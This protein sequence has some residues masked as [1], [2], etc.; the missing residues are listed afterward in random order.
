MKYPHTTI[1]QLMERF[2][3]ELGEDYT[4]YKNHVY[5]VFSY[6]CLIDTDPANE[7]KYAVAAVFHDIGIWTAH[8]FDYLEPSIAQVNSY[9]N[10]AGHPEWTEEVTGMIYWHHKLS[11]YKGRYQKLVENFRRADWIDVSLGLLAFSTD[12]SKIAQI[13]TKFPNAGFHLFLLKQSAR[14]FIQHPFNPLPV[15]KK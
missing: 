5:R 13:R 9:L 7:E 2:E 15:F 12:K 11:P 10:T 8:T 14:N 1:E 6:C 4:R 3:P